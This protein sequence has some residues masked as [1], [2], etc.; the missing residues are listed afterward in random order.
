[1]T[2]AAEGAGVVAAEGAVTV[3]VV[4]AVAATK[5]LEA[6][7]GAATSFAAILHTMLHAAPAPHQ[8][9]PAPALAC[10]PV[11]PF[12]STVERYARTHAN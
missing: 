1:M 11:I 7:Q 8:Q 5:P 2:V 4:A 9:E 10:R 6:P 12:Q 3:V